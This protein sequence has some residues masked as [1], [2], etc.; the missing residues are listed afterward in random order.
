MQHIGTDERAVEINNYWM[1]F[2]AQPAKWITSRASG[3]QAAHALLAHVRE[4]NGVRD[5]RNAAII[6]L[7]RPAS[8]KE[9]LAS[10]SAG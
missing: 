3:E 4:M 5:G 1:Q 10:R 6:G 8:K 2:C 9:A 7:N